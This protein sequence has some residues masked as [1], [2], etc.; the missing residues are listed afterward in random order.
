MGPATT[1]ASGRLFRRSPIVGADEAHR[2]A[3]GREKAEKPSIAIDNKR[4]VLSWPRRLKIRTASRHQ[5]RRF[6][7][8]WTFSDIA[9]RDRATALHPRRHRRAEPKHPPSRQQIYSPRT[10]SAP[11]PIIGGGRRQLPTGARLTANQEVLRARYYSR[12]STA[13]QAFDPLLS[14][15]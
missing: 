4:A 11:Q 7:H 5:C 12:C 6:R 2:A 9:G 13:S 1:L 3:I 8:H 10:V 14:R 15:R